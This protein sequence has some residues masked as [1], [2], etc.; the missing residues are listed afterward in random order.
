MDDL[1]RLKQVVD[2]AVVASTALKKEAQQF[3]SLAQQIHTHVKP[4]LKFFAVQS[5]VKSEAE[6]EADA[7][8][9]QRGSSDV[10]RGHT[11]GSLAGARASEK[12]GAAGRDIGEG[13]GEA[14]AR[15]SSARAPPQPA[16]RMSMEVEVEVE[17]EEGEERGEEGGEEAGDRHAL[18]VSASPILKEEYS[19]SL[20]ETP[21][22]AAV[23]SPPKSV[24]V[25]TIK[26]R[27]QAASVPS[28][29]LSSPH[30]T[31]NDMSPPKSTPYRKVGDV[32]PSSPTPTMNSPPK[33]VKL[34]RGRGGDDDT[35]THFD[36][37]RRLSMS[38]RADEYEESS[39][40]PGTPGLDSPTRIIP[41]Q[42]EDRT[43]AAAST[44]RKRRRESPAAGDAPTSTSKRAKQGRRAESAN[45]GRG[46]AMVD[47]DPTAAVVEL[48]FS[49]FPSA[50]RSG[51]R[52]EELQSVYDLLRSKAGVFYL[53]E[54]EAELPSL[55]KG[56]VKLLL[57]LLVSREVAMEKDISH[58]DRAYWLQ[59]C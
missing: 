27:G 1:L 16:S 21:D 17:S 15:V 35:T 53:D 18:S 56:K 28:P 36:P 6:A 49:L 44:A 55:G 14:S 29:A 48:D 7:S 2:R 25:T 51:A 5:G 40:L 13:E 43:P 42:V 41:L 9:H 39:T 37:A 54:A 3:V 10:S 31:F 23:A 57:D 38:Y 19:S 59:R 58:G 4:M 26:K 32:T 24:K 30:P 33:S 12:E 22:M 46:E 34:A 52:K 50:F 8:L 11:S 45:A 47:I 20:P